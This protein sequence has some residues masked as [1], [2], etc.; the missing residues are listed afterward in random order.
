MEWGTPERAAQKSF[1]QGEN[2]PSQGPLALFLLCLHSRPPEVPTDSELTL[3][4]KAHPA[5][6]AGQDSLSK[7]S[8]FLNKSPLVFCAWGLDKDEVSEVRG[9]CKMLRRCSLP[10][11][12]ESVCL[13]KYCSLEASL[14]LLVL[15]QNFRQKES[16]P[17]SRGHSG[18]FP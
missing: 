2:S 18:A 12:P 6:P 7:P 1:S 14:S 17:G 15:V 9:V 13:L 10:G 8:G 4:L 3:P 5:Q 16:V 11:N